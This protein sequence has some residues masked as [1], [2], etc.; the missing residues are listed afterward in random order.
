MPADHRT[1]TAGSRCG[2]SAWAALAAFTALAGVAVAQDLPSAETQAPRPYQISVNVNLVVLHATVLNK[3]GGFATGLGEQDFDVYEDGVRQ[4]I[5]LFQH[6]D[7]P[8]TVGL[9]VDHSGSMHAKVPDVL[10]AARTFVAS[11]NKEDQMFV[12]NFNEHVTMGLTG[13]VRFT[14][15]ADELEAAILRAPVAG[16]TALYEAIMVGLTRLEEG[17]RDKKVLVVI[18]DG[19][20]NASVLKMP[21][22]LKKAE[23]SNAIIYTVG[24][25]DPDDPDTNPDVLRRLAK[26][27]GGEA[28]F[29]KEYSDTEPIC[30]RIAADIRN[31]Y[32]IGYVSTNPAQAGGYRAIRVAARA[33]GKEVLVR[34]RAGY[35][36]GAK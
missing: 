20:D 5:Q 31:Q 6:E 32:T 36:A 18:S 25:F 8:V 19:G 16:Q 17:N 28:F 34:T 27:T 30:Q 14:N 11:S 10:A 3:K 15:R 7:V 22:V 33:P 21:Q 24:I 26:A 4:S 29:P 1:L 35:I 2:K 13:A 9:V 23:E 12:V